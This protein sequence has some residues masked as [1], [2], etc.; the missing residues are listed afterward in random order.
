MYVFMRVSELDEKGDTPVSTARRA[1]PKPV[2][3]D[4]TPAETSG[5]KIEVGGSI[6]IRA[7]HRSGF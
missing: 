6:Q 1:E 7:G 4:E 3:P 5:P 2:E